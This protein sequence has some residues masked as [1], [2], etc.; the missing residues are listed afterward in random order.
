MSPVRASDSGV[1]G[2]LLPSPLLMDALRAS[3]EAH[4]PQRLRRADAVGGRM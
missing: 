2:W 4:D 3:S 1:P